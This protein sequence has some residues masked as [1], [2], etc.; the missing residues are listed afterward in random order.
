M[1]SGKRKD[2]KPNPAAKNLV[3]GRD[4][5][6]LR[7]LGLPSTL[8]YNPVATYQRGMEL[9]AQ[10]KQIEAELT[11][12]EDSQELQFL[13]LLPWWKERLEYRKL[14]AEGKAP[15]VTWYEA[16]FHLEQALP[17][18][19]DHDHEWGLY[20]YPTRKKKAKE[21]LANPEE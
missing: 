21:A 5:Q 9:V 15:D 8:L 13:E 11:V 1:T 7:I 6:N 17:Y 16:L 4:R 18:R 10:L 3:T 20:T 12:W 2:G 19:L 14:K